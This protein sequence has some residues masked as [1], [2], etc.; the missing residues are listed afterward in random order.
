MLNQ[1]QSSKQKIKSALAFCSSGFLEELLPPLRKL[2]FPLQFFLICLTASDL[3][4]LYRVQH[5]LNWLLEMIQQQATQNFKAKAEFL[6]LKKIEK[7]G[8]RDRTV[9][10]KQSELISSQV[11][12]L[13]VK[14]KKKIFLFSC[15]VL[16]QLTNI[17]LKS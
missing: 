17:T 12:K 11:H 1:G 16:T 10:E 9:G 5:L 2:V 8:T 13:S 15:S 4:E 3:T 6:D 7:G 14:K